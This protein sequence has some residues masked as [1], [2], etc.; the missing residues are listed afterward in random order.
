MSRLK[1]KALESYQFESSAKIR[2]SD[3]NYGNHLGN[4]ALVSLIHNARVELLS[5]H[6]F[7]ELNIGQEKVGIIMSGLQVQYRAEGFLHDTLTIQSDFTEFSKSFF[8]ACHLVMRK[9]TVIALVECDFT[10]FNY[11]TRK[12]ASIPERFL[13]TFNKNEG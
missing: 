2:V 10:A 12:I 5:K 3:L 11:S 7:S 4:D 6:G 13:Q 9:D 1:L 8:K